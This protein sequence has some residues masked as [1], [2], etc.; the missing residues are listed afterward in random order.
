[1]HTAAAVSSFSPIAV[2]QQ[3]QL[4]QG[5]DIDILHHLW[6]PY[7]HFLLFLLRYYSMH[8]YLLYIDLAN[9]VPCL[10]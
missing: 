1:M 10:Q 4:G 5:K 3:Q 8:G 6:Y 7:I 9:L 2:T